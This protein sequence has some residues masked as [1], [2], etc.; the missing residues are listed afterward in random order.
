MGPRGRNNHRLMVQFNT[1]KIQLFIL[2]SVYLQGDIRKLDGKL[3][4]F[5]NYM[6]LNETPLRAARQGSPIVKNLK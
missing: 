5:Y 2:P 3:I 6:A 4:T 1:E